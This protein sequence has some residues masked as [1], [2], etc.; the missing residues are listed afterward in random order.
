M[1]NL[2]QLRWYNAAMSV[3]HLVQAGAMYFL[4]ND[5]A[6]PINTNYLKFNQELQ[7]LVPVRE[8]VLEFQV[9]PVVALFLLLSAIAHFLLSLPT[10]NEWYLQKLKE[11][12]NPAR[13]WEYTLSSSVMIVVIAMLVGIYDL[14]ALLLMFSIN[15]VMILC[16]WI[17]EVHNQTTSK[18]NW[19]S[20]AVGCFAGVVPWIVIGLHLFGSG[21]GENKPPDF[22]YWIFFS[23]FLFFNSFALNMVLQYKKTGPWKNYTFGEK[24]YIF[25]S[26]IA[27]SALA[28]QVWAGTLR[29]E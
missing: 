22:V 4:S 19:L 8:Q 10:I 26:L 16:G 21:D 5:F 12:M 2:S 20:Y 24:V 17:M 23:I 1:K 7:K 18:T 13:W 29:P 28:W 9:G 6:L 15:A 14:S 11:G 27:K 3:L 25:M